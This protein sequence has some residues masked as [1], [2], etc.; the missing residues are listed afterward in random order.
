[1]NIFHTSPCCQGIPEATENAELL[2]LNSK[3]SHSPARR[4]LQHTDAPG[5]AASRG[6]AES[7]Q[8]TPPSTVGGTAIGGGDP[9]TLCALVTTVRTARPRAAHRCE[10][11][12]SGQNCKIPGTAGTGRA[13]KIQLCS[14]A[15][16]QQTRETPRPRPALHQFYWLILD[17]D[18]LLCPRRYPRIDPRRPRSCCARGQEVGRVK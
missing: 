16:R 1:M 2:T 17:I 6:S 8:K 11:R 5:V 4:L 9:V 15:L 13:Y 3:I 12:N 14:E 7:V 10:I 18:V